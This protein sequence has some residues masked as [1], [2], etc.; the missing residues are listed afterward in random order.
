MK[1][2]RHTG[3]R[4]TINA[5][6][7]LLLLSQPPP[8]KRRKWRKATAR[9]ETLI[10]G[11]GPATSVSPGRC[12]C[13]SSRCQQQER[14]RPGSW[15]RTPCCCTDCPTLGWLPRETNGS[16]NRARALLA[17]PS[18]LAQDCSQSERSKASCQ[19]SF[20]KRHL[21]AISLSGEGILFKNK[22]V[23]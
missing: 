8:W 4:C 11:S 7:T 15:R 14:D 12:R 22:K 10:Q 6:V 2:Y 1:M 9:W 13:S 19:N 18:V 17:K 20:P 5:S 21:L 16:W 3:G 23:A